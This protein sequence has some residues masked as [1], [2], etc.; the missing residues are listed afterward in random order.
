MYFYFRPHLFFTFLTSVSP[1]ATT[2]I[3]WHEIRSLLTDFW[4]PQKNRQNRH[5]IV[6]AKIYLE[7]IRI[8]P[9]AGNLFI[10]NTKEELL[11]KMMKFHWKLTRFLECVPSVKLDTKQ[12]TDLLSTLLHKHQDHLS[13]VK[14]FNPFP[15][16]L[17][18][19]ETLKSE[20]WKHG[21]VLFT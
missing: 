10:F 13:L 1:P 4:R 8:L 15:I 9:E 11:T 17:S 18:N 20:V 5:L 12:F 21:F 14:H 7:R 2:V 6:T 16:W 3:F 19:F